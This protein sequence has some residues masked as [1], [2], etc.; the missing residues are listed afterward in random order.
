MAIGTTVRDSNLYKDVLMEAVAAKF[1]DKKALAGTDVVSMIPTLPKMS[2]M[3]SKLGSGSQIEVPYFNSIGEL[4]DVPENGSLTPRKLTSSKETTTIISSGLAG[5]ITD[6]ARIAA[7]AGDP[8]EALSAQFVEAVMRR[9]DAGLITKALATS[10]LHDKTGSTIT[11]DFVIEASEKW[12]DQLDETDG[13]RLLIVHSKVRQK[14]RLLRDNSGGAGT[15]T[16]LYKDSV[17]GPNGVIA[18]PTFA[19]IPVMCSDRLSPTGNVYPS[20]LC[21][22]GAMVAWYNG[23][24]V[25]ESDRDI[26][27]ASDVTAM[28][29]LHAEHLYRA[30]TV[31]S[32]KPGVVKLLTTET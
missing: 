6:W 30:A 27:A 31:D 17:I 20:L 22:R 15:G 1:A 13:I 28:H 14:L 32:I 10:L 8:Y 18:L 21:K 4:E 12:G 19:G 11:E 16:R 29:V 25:I 24:P 23:E 26:L 5:E 3:G 2:V 7:Q 9:I